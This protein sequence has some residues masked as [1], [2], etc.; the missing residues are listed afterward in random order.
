[1]EI[2][3]GLGATAKPL[4]P[5]PH[6]L[7][8]SITAPRPGDGPA[9]GSRQS[10]PPRAARSASAMP[11][12]GSAGGKDW[13]LT[14]WV[15]RASSAWRRS[16]ADRPGKRVAP[17][18]IIQNI[19]ASLEPTRATGRVSARAWAVELLRVWSSPALKTSTPT[20]IRARS[21]WASARRMA[22][23]VRL[24][25]PRAAGCA[26]TAHPP[27]SATRRS[28]SS[29]DSPFGMGCWINRASRCPSA[30]ETSLPGM[31]STP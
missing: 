31:T 22:S 4:P 11:S 10:S 9:R 17:A 24:F 26:A 2:E 13:P 8:P 28:V 15:W 27:R 23:G 29:S 5:N 18:P 3:R 7:P 25:I 30:V 21:G 20:R 1:M 14:G 19:W 6:T 16:W 12:A